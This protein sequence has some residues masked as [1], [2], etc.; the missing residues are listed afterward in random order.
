MR[1][2]Y[3]HLGMPKTGTSSIQKAFFGYEDERLAY[4][5][6]M[7]P[8]HQTTLSAI[9]SNNPVNFPL[10]QSMEITEEKIMERVAGMRRRFE[11]ELESEKDIVFSGESI[12]YRL[13]SDKMGKLINSLKEKFDRVIA[14]AYIRPLAA[15]VSSQFQQRIKTGSRKGFKG[16][17]LPDPTYRRLFEKVLHHAGEENTLFIRFD[18]DDLVGGDVVA[19]FSHRIGVKTPPTA[20]NINESFSAE[21]VG[22]LY[23]FNKYTAP[24]LQPKMA[25]QMRRQL[26]EALRGVGTTKFGLAPALIEAHLEMHKDDV[27]WMERV[28]RFDVKGTVKPVPHPIETEEQL[29]RIAERAMPVKLRQ[30]R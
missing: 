28:C 5:K 9:F 23:A 27:A 29:L 21:A 20:D 13:G 26:K 14:I 3:L 8:N 19:D 25:T 6:L 10:F 17:E 7:Q 1:T 24:W 18:R 11:R 22:A 12:I 30:A 16:F 15:L 4:A 2:C